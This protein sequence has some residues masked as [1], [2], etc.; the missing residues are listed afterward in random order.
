MKPRV[1]AADLNSLPSRIVEGR[2]WVAWAIENRQGKPTKVPRRPQR[3]HVRAS[4]TDPETWGTLDEAIAAA[5][6][7]H[8]EGVGRV[9]GDGLV[10]LDLDGCRNPH[11]GHIRPEAA[12]IVSKLNSYT[13]L[14]P[15]GTGLHVWCEGRLPS[16][17]NRRGP[18][19]LYEHD[20]YMTVTG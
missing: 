9:L 12:V 2:R 16:G 3:P 8:V 15:S 7:E 11:T 6:L 20:R 17:G 14:S 4:A 5:Q 13:E 1:V 19:E 18:I 10:V